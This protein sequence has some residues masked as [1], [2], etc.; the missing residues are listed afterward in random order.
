MKAFFLFLLT[1]NTAVNKLQKV[2]SN[3]LTAETQ[4]SC[5]FRMYHLGRNN[6]N[7]PLFW[8]LDCSI[9]FP[10]TGREKQGWESVRAKNLTVAITP[11]TCAAF[12]IW[13]I[14]FFCTSYLSL[15]KYISQILESSP[16]G[17]R[18]SCDVE[19]SMSKFGQAKVNWSG[20]SPYFFLG[21]D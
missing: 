21:G 14:L 16:M 2:K 4:L 7:K 10:C 5:P 19:L 9:Y 15:S 6:V 11:K 20:W 13:S 17:R 3:T 1:I 18:L 12:K 8:P